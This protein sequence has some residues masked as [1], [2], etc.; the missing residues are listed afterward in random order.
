V[1]P[2]ETTGAVVNV[3]RSASAEQLVGVAGHVVRR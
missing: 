1:L 2:L 3:C